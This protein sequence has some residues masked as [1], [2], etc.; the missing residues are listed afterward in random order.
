MTYV[1]ALAE[2]IMKSKNKQTRSFRSKKNYPHRNDRKEQA[3]E[4]MLADYQQPPFKKGLQ[5]DLKTFLASK[6][7]VD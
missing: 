1:G 4:Q 7:A 3:M 2:K 5:D 6:D